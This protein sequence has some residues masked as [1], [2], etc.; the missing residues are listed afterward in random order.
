[1]VGIIEEMIKNQVPAT[2]CIK[3]VDEIT[4]AVV[5]IITDI[6]FN[7]FSEKMRFNAHKTVFNMPM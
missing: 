6:N 5:K 4:N 2:L 3:N 1:M 7:K